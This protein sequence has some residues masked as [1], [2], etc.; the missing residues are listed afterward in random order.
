MFLYIIVNNK[1]LI[2]AMQNFH[3]VDYYSDSQRVTLANRNCFY[4]AIQCEILF[5]AKVISNALIDSIGER[6]AQIV[7]KSV[8]I[9]N[10]QI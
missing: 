10:D 8:L 4:I 1:L 9:R 2:D 7:Y 5:H 3:F 6:L